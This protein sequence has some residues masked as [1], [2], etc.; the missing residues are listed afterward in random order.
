MAASGVVT[1]DQR[2]VFKVFGSLSGGRLFHRARA[3]E[4]R[5][6]CMCVWGCAALDQV[7]VRLNETNVAN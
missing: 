6:S 7:G 2:K 3:Y 5:C 4:F 1:E